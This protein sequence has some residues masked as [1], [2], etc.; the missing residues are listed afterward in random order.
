MPKFRK[1]PVV[2]EAVRLDDNEISILLVERFIEGKEDIGH[3]SCRSADDAWD[4]WVDL[5]RKQGGRKILT[6][7]GEMLA[8]FGDWIIKGVN[9]EYYPCKPEIFE[10]TY[11]KVED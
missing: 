2:I 5:L 8:Q 4:N 6:L 10:K 11:E 1:K 7:E 3:S 9:G